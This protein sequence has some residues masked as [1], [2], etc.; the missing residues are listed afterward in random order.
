LNIFI[1]RQ[2]IL[3]V[4]TTFLYSCF[5]LYRPRP[6]P[7]PRQRKSQKVEGGHLRNS[8]NFQEPAASNEEQGRSRPSGNYVG[9]TFEHR[10]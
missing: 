8:Q 1:F 2:T 6:V 9:S 10:K 7:V 5:V 3:C 4:E